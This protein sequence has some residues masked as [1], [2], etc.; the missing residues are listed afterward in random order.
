[1]TIFKAI[2]NGAGLS[3]RRS[4]LILYL[5]FANTAVALVA[6]APLFA[7]MRKE[8]GQSLFGRS[9]RT[10]DVL[11]LGEMVRSYQNI[12]PALLAWLVLFLIIFLLLS[13]FLNG[14]VIGRLLDGEGRTTLGT[15]LGDCGTYFWRFFR[16][17]LIS[18]PFTLVALLIFQ[19]ILS[20]LTGPLV[21]N[22]RTEWTSLIVSNLEFIAILLVLALVHILFDYARILLV[23]DKETRV[24]RALL[25]AFRFVRKRIFRAWFLYLLLVVLFLA[26]TGLH[27]LV[28]GVLP[29]TNLVGLAAGLIW[30]QLYLVFRIWTRLLIFSSEYNYYT[31]NPF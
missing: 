31:A 6:A 17:F 15:F 29:T 8:L 20:L 28:S 7:L 13:V 11:W 24:L 19:K 26:G 2:G 30:T 4:K 10:F 18:L 12:A 22:A 27:F 3:L 1:M 16:I 5:W 9:V 23:A 14:G 21:E 25:G